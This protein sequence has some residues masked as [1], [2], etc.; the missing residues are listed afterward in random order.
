MRTITFIRFKGREKRFPKEVSVFHVLQS[1]Q[2]AFPSILVNFWLQFKRRQN[3]SF[4]QV[5]QNKQTD[6]I[7]LANMS[8]TNFSHGESDH[9]ITHAIYIG[10]KSS[11]DPPVQLE[12]VEEAQDELKK[13][14]KEVEE[15]KKILKK[16]IW[17][18]SKKSTAHHP[19]GPGSVVVLQWH[20]QPVVLG[21]ILI[22]FGAR[23]IHLFPRR[24]RHCFLRLVPRNVVFLFFFFLIVSLLGFLFICISN[25]DL[26]P[27]S[28]AL[29][30]RLAPLG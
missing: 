20:L 5:V 29:G 30:S 8:S 1:N 22:H 10:D 9:P 4:I 18:A 11:C 13:K 3:Y 7:C 24:R 28:V 15:L 17:P 27:S 14:K 12:C 25:T 19:E 16:K 2:P 21:S 23:L 6:K 26:S